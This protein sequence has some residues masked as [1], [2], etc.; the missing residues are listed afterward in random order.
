MTRHITWQVLLIA[1]GVVLVG[2][3]LT[4][5]AVNYTTVVRPGT[6]GT[7]VEGVA[8]YPR[9]LN[10]L[11][12]GF[13]DVDRDLCALVFSGL[14]RLN[15]RGEPVPDLA[16]SW[17]VAITPQGVSYT[18][19]LRSNAYWHDGQPLTADDVIFTVGLLQDPGFPGPA[20]L[21]SAVWQTVVV[22]RIDRRTVKFTLPQPY[23]P[24]LDYTTVGIL[25]VHRLGGVS[26]AELP[27]VAF[28]LNPIGSGP[29][30]LEE[31]NIEGDVVSSMVLKRFPRYHGRK[32]FLDRIQ[33]RF[34]PSTQAV[35]NA[36]EANEIGGIAE[37]PREEL[38][39]TRALTNLNLYS[40][41]T[42]ELSLVLFNLRDAEELPFFQDPRVRQAL[43]YAIDRQQMV[44]D[45]LDGQALVA[46]SPL[47][48]RTWAYA[49]DL[50][51]YEYDP[52]RANV[53]LDE[54][55]W[56]RQG[57]GERQRR[58]EGRWFGF[59]LVTSSEPERIALAET[60][61]EQWNA[62][63]MTVTV[64]SVSPLELRQ[65]LDARD[66]D[67]IIVDMAIP[68]DPDP[69]AFWH[70]TQID[71]GQNYAG[72]VHRRASEVLEQARIRIEEGQEGRW[73]LYHEFQD[74]FA[75]EVPALLL[76][77]PIY[78]Y[79]VDA[80]IHNVQLGPIMHRSDRFRT[81]ADWWIVPRRVIVSDAEVGGP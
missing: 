60:L 39:R 80:R 78:T 32:A 61:A 44:E 4:Y 73:A 34:Y 55:G 12:S 10:P 30:Q 13:S 67:M 20:E 53:L 56:V 51:H 43:L 42:A 76:Y 40:A 45:T 31:V 18:F 50:R 49:D 57:V 64:K 72:F 65:A 59:E 24:F 41:R 7:Y 16:R 75:E 74:I 9:T 25:P 8:G 11:L 81:L 26:A 47:I 37:I 3:L 79:G 52:E 29:F 46:H 38:A 77:V 15:E 62:L 58:K 1:L 54:A 71:Q 17:E 22:D 48:P 23:A 14:T 6:G 35:L 2:I 28:N 36:Y 70:E 27:G 69:Y 19:N 66:F 21:G 68:G 63:G 5:L 33:F